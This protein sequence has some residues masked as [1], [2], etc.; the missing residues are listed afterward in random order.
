MSAIRLNESDRAYKY[1]ALLRS[2]SGAAGFH[3]RTC[4]LES[5]KI[6]LQA[7]DVCKCGDLTLVQQI[8]QHGLLV[9]KVAKRVGHYRLAKRRG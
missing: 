5:D 9:E 7:A 6:S 4:Q 3:G 8:L 1:S 2:L